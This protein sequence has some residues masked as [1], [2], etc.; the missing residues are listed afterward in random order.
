MVM[1]ASQDDIKVPLLCGDCLHGRRHEDFDQ[2]ESRKV[3][4]TTLDL[5]SA[6]RQL[7]VR[8]DHLWSCVLVAHD[9]DRGLPAY[10]VLRALPFGAVSAVD[11]FLRTSI[12]VRHVGQAVLL[13]AWESF[14]DDFPLME[15]SALSSTSRLAALGLFKRLGWLVSEEKLTG[16]ESR[17]V[18]LGVE[19][20]TVDAHL[21]L[22]QVGNKPGR[23]EE[24][25]GLIREVL[26]LERVPLHELQKLRGKLGFA[27]AQTMGRWPALV[28]S[29]LSLAVVD[30]KLEVDTKEVLKWFAER[31]LTIP[32]RE[33]RVHRGARPWVLFTDGALDQNTA[34]IGAVLLDTGINHA[35]WFKSLVPEEFKE[36]WLE[37]GIVDAICQIE[38]LAIVTAWSTWGRVMR[39]SK[40]IAFVDNNAAL[41]ALIKNRSRSTSMRRLLCSLA[42]LDAQFHIMAWF[43]RVPSFSNCADGPSR[44]KSFNM[45]G[46][47]DSVCEVVWPVLRCEPWVV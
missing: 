15:F 26:A 35:R 3:V 19:F 21:G 2:P 5:A 42:D 41:D 13:L 10:V 34:S 11:S 9:P 20:S 27:A 45:K 32:P 24:V 39:S 31:L 33:I 44:L 28:L 29:F 16:M 4:G 47:S 30:G 43:E 23:A 25:V 6:Y 40:C 36:V 14:F 1:C 22:V 17:F 38:L 12:A 7:P 18:A 37:S 8:P 46:W